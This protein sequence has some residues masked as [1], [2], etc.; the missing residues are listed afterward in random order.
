MTA[1]GIRIS[2]YL[3][4]EQ[5]GSTGLA[6]TYLAQDTGKGQ[7]VVLKMLRSYFSQE[8]ALFNSFKEEM[9]R[10][11]AAPS[12]HLL[13]PLEEH[14]E[15][16]CWFVREYTPAQSL[17]TIWRGPAPLAAVL[18]IV[19]GVAEA[20]EHLLGLGQPHRNLKPSNIFWDADRTT[21][22]LADA[23][24]ATLARGSHPLMRLSITTPLP[25]FMA[26]EYIDG[27]QA[28]ARSEVFSLAVLT[29]WLLTG[30]VPYQ[31][32]APAT[33]YAKVMSYHAPP[34]SSLNPELS[35]EVDRFLLRA[36][37]PF[38]TARPASP[39]TF[40]Q[41]LRGLA[42]GDAQLSAAATSRPGTVWTAAQRRAAS[43]GV[44]IVPPSSETRPIWG[45]D[46]TLDH[47][48][49]PPSPRNLLRERLVQL[50]L[51]VTAVVAIVMGNAA[52]SYTPDL[53]PP[54]SV[55]SAAVAP[56]QWVLPRYD[57]RNSGHTPINSSHIQGALAWK[58]ET[59][60][61]LLS[62]PTVADGVVYLTTGDKRVMALDAA[63]GAVRWQISVTG[64]VDAAPVVAGDLLYVGL[65]DTRV[66]ALDKQT[67]QQR[68]EF[69]TKNPIYSSGIIERGVLYQGSADGHV[70]ALD[71]ATGDFR[72][73]FNS[74]AWITTTPSVRED[75][76]VTADRNGWLHAVDTVTGK[77]L[78]HFYTGGSVNHSVALDGNRGYVIADP[79]RLF[80]VDID[81]RSSFKDWEI[82]QMLVRFYIWGIWPELPHHKGRVWIAR[83]SGRTTS[84]LAIAHDKVYLGTDRSRVLAFE[85]ESGKVAWEYRAAAPMLGSPTVTQD[86]LYIGG[87]DGKLHAFNPH[88]GEHLW[89]F[90]TKGRILTSPAVANNMV[91][92]TS[93]DGTLYALR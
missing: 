2:S 40:A 38:G 11:R 84:S 16:P 25:S 33:M 7:R 69:S 63:T 86:T 34:P 49:S 71:A 68:W 37:A 36:L 64:P 42:T 9:E 6:T 61:P 78:F 35:H 30:D 79:G 56:D 82:Y 59:K 62:S 22:Q 29:Y 8:E 3:V 74:D 17:Q 39:R 5:L 90:P 43:S 53:A 28:D 88:T 46:A 75:V 20:Q 44:P 87:N 77:E 91:Y 32:D 19:E 21:V 81:E 93:D 57:W 13:M 89:E 83:V 18:P 51:A 55:V 92:F 70:Y 76:V 48:W 66:L 1:I 58:L 85:T 50:T 80:A 31:A 4:E 12:P 67:G 24:L 27:N 73:R 41:E 23:G 14:F 15:D 60:E 54:T 45:S 72:W 47:V 52:L 26:P 10:L 65:R